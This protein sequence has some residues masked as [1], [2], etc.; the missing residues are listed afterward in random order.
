MGTEIGGVLTLEGASLKGATDIQGRVTGYA[1]SADR[2]VIGGSVFCSPADGHR[3]E[4]EGTVRLMGATIGGQLALDDAWLNAPKGLALA[5]E[6]ISVSDAT[7]LAGGT[8]IVGM[9]NLMGATLSDLF[10]QGEIKATTADANALHLG[11]ASLRRLWIDGLSGLGK[12][13]LEGATA[14]TFDGFYPELWGDAPTATT[15]LELDLDGFTYRRADSAGRCLNA[16]AP[17]PD[18]HPGTPTPSPR[19]C[20]SCWT[21][22]FATSRRAGSTICRNRS[23]R[24]PGAARSGL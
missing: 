11:D 5:A 20:W 10:V 2:A 23:R 9:V 22:S 4:A 8:A 16:I 24:R 7:I 14:D 6:R 17:G 19:M 1:L 13:N 3:F 18:S 12:V 21:A 15:G